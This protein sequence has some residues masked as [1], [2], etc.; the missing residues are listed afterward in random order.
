MNWFAQC[1]RCQCNKSG[2]SQF[3][4][5]ADPL[6]V[7]I[8]DDVV[9]HRGTDIAADTVSVCFQKA[10]SRT[11]G[12]TGISIHSKT[13]TLE[14]TRTGQ[15]LRFQAEHTQHARLSA[16]YRIYLTG[17]AHSFRN[18]FATALFRNRY[19]V[20]FEG[21]S[22]DIREVHIVELHAA[23]LLQLLLNAAA[24]FQGQL[25]NFFQVF[26]CEFTVRI[27]E[28]QVA[29]YHPA[30]SNGITLIQ[31]LSQTEI[32]I[33]SIA[34]LLLTEF[35]DEFCQVIGDETIVVGEVLWTELGNLP[36]RQIAVHTIKECCIRA[37][38]NGEWVEQTGGFQEN[39]H[40]LVDISYE[41][42]G[43]RRSLLLLAAGKGTRS[44]VVLH[45]LHAVFIFEPDACHFIERN[46][47]PQPNQANCLSPHV[48]EQVGYGRLAAGNQDAVR[49][50]LFIQ[51]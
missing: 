39:I 44:H 38:L 45:D 21:L 46:T 3:A 6:K 17:A 7:L 22:I 14:F 43:C 25:Q 49:R 18:E 48:V 51:V 23:Q 34:V 9:L 26:F 32:V 41:H 40:T 19:I 4:G 47:I 35:A 8:V 12:F 36:S 16:R 42:H 11:T 2:H 30:N 15:H 24:H 28:F 27:N 33:Q 37:H 1:D 29:I 5:H 13:S 50:N 10:K 31:I 20:F